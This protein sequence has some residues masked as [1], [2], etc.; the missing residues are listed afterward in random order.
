MK[1]KLLQ[2]FKGLHFGVFI[3]AILTLL[4][5]GFTACTSDDDEK[6]PEKPA[7]VLSEY[8][9]IQNATIVSGTIPSN[10]NG[11]SIRRGGYVIPHV[12]T[13]RMFHP[14]SISNAKMPALSSFHN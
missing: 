7:V 2:G 5:I 9:S 8:F 1:K 4:A 3:V 10:P 13:I 6:I 11:L 12:I 14:I